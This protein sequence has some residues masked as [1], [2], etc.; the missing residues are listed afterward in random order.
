M[1]NKFIDKILNEGKVIT[2]LPTAIKYLF[3]KHGEYDV[4][5]NSIFYQPYDHELAS[6]LWEL[7]ESYTENN[8]E[9]KYH[10]LFLQTGMT[11]ISVSIEEIYPSQE[12]LNSD[13][14]IKLMNVN[15]FNHLPQAVKI[16]N[17]RYNYI[18]LSDGHHRV[19]SEILKGK[20]KI[21]LLLKVDNFK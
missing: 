13:K 9:D 17:K 15:K 8:S 5:I 3:P 7:D 20:K 6:L 21:D 19:A 14:L 4:N 1:K 10:A 18:V 11:K 2:E 16:K 12:G